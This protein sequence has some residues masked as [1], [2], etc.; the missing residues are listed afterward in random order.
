MK[1]LLPLPT[2]PSHLDR[3]ANIRNSKHLVTRDVLLANH[4]SIEARFTALANHVGAGTLDLIGNSPLMAISNELRLCYGS[5]TKA[6]GILTTAIKDAQ[7]DGQLKYCPYCQTTLGGTIDHYL[8]AI[9]FPEFAVHP[10]NLVPSC[11]KCNS[12]K[13]DDWLNAAGQ[14]LYLHFYTDVMP[15]VDFL[16]VELVTSP[17]LRSVGARFNLVQAGIPD[18]DWRLIQS[19]FRKL[20]LIERYDDQGSNEIGEMLESGQSYRQAGGTDV[21][22]FF[23]LEAGKAEGRYGR[24]HWRGKILRAL[25]AYNELDNLTTP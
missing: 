22:H 3:Y 5:G 1:A 8:P 10:L 2:P 20:K 14:R 21:V 15:A 18:Q 13:G 23:E 4:A 12:T 9:T 24:N 16:E 11:A 25:A 19:H 6:L 17:A 7:S